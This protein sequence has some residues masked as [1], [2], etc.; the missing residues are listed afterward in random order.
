MPVCNV[1]ACCCSLWVCCTSF[2]IT[3]IRLHSCRLPNQNHAMQSYHWL[4]WSKP[5][6]GKTIPDTNLL[7]S[8]LPVLVT[9]RPPLHHCTDP[10]LLRCLLA[11]NPLS[12]LTWQNH[13]A[14]CIPR[15]AMTGVSLRLHCQ[16]IGALRIVGN[17]ISCMKARVNQFFLNRQHHCPLLQLLECRP[18]AFLERDKLFPHRVTVLCT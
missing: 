18:R 10:K 17:F 16:S 6:A 11:S 14:S 2:T 15:L 4:I 5:M 13:S 7:P 9:G 3:H 8:E 1:G 12:P